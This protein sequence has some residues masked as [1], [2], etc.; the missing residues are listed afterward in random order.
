MMKNSE[1][2]KIL[3]PSE[4]IN[5]KIQHESDSDSDSVDSIKINDPIENISFRNSK[6]KGIIKPLTSNSN[7]DPSCSICN[8]D[9]LN[10]SG[11][12]CLC[13]RVICSYHMILVNNLKYCT[14]CKQHDS[15]KDII[16]A[17]TEHYIKIKTRNK[18]LCCFI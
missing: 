10:A 6:R 7:M 13:N 5:N 2:N 16:Q 1:C 4:M 11:V 15:Y 17:N 18:W 3:K 14:I 9:K 12:C 8:V